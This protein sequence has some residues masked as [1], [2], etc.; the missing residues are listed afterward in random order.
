MGEK[1]RGRMLLS[2]KE[3]AY[4]LDVHPETLRRWRRQGAVLR[5]RK[6]GGRWYYDAGEVERVREGDGDTQ[7]RA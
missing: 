3:A 6:I 2:T 5:A 1:G 7:T 4:E